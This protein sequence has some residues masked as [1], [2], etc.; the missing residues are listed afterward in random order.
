MGAQLDLFCPKGERM[1]AVDRFGM[2][3]TNQHDLFVSQS[4]KR[5]WA[6]CDSCLKSWRKDR[7][8][9]GLRPL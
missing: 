7:R 6:E 3:L 2:V 5:K 8:G 1:V 4:V 9:G